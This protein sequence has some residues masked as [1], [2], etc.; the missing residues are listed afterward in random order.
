LGNKFFDCCFSEGLNRNDGRVTLY[1]T[2]LQWPN[3]R[4]LG[5]KKRLIG[6]FKIKNMLISFLKNQQQLI[7]VIM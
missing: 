5:I 2:A 4:K 3:D 6:R 7:Y 1:I